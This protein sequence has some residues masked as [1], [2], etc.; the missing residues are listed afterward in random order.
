M[1][2]EPASPPMAAPDGGRSWGPVATLQALV[3][4]GG[5]VRG[6]VDGLGTFAVVAGK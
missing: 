3:A 2:F 5:V 6:S 1:L 4:A